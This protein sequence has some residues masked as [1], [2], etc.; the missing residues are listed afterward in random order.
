MIQGIGTK[1]KI[2]ANSVVELTSIDGLDLSADTIEKTTLDS[3][4]W[5][6]FAQGIKDAGE[7]ACTGFFNPADTTGQKAMYDAFVTGTLT[8]FT[9][10]FPAT[11]GAEWDFN[12]IVTGIK[13]SAAIEDGIPFEGKLKVSGAP[14]LGLTA[15]GGLTALALTAAGGALSPAF[16]N[17]NYSY[18]FGG[19]TATS[20]TVT[21]TAAAHT[22]KLFIDG[23][24]SQDLVSASPS[25]AIALTLNVGKKL[26]I[27]AYEAAKTIKVYE[28]VVI[29]T[30]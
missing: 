23:V 14:S 13:T 2:G 10:L 7:V 15:S 16:A 18:S 25:N 11:L 12:A 24:Y 5:R 3:A 30:A 19:V 17:T 21:A 9:I 20:V 26:T 22:L 28:I 6:E 8:A 29:K 27:L 1:L 4:G